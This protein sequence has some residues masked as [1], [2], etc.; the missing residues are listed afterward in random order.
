MQKIETGENGNAP[1]GTQPDAALPNVVT[2]FD[3]AMMEIGRSYRTFSRINKHSYPSSLGAFNV[4]V[5][6][7]GDVGPYR[8]IHP[9]TTGTGTKVA[10]GTVIVREVLGASGEVTK[11]TLMAKGPA[12]YDDTLG[13]WWFGEA[14]PQGNPTR[15]GRLADCHG[16]HIP[17]AST[18]YLFGVPKDAER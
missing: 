15:M 9:E 10:V 16:C 11:L 4:N 14:D 6:V 17:R 2:D 7:H 18:D 1:T 5:F 3:R 12:G 13:D 8:S